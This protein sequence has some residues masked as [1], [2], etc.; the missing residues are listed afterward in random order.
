MTKIQLEKNIPPPTIVGH[1]AACIVL[2]Y[3]GLFITQR[4]I[5]RIDYTKLVP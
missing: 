5:I 2:Y 3:L 1:S 4:Y